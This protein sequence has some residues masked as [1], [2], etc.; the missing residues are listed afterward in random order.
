MWMG[1]KSHVLVKIKFSPP[2]YIEVGPTLSHAMPTFNVFEA[3][4]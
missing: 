1:A 4:A 2:T 3:E